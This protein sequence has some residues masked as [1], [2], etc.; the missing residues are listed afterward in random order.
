MGFKNFMQMSFTERK[1]LVS[2]AWKQYSEYLNSYLI[3]EETNINLWN[4]KHPASVWLTWR[5]L[6]FVVA[7]WETSVL[8]QRWEASLEGS[9]TELSYWVTQLTESIKVDGMMH[10][11]WF[12]H[13]TDQ[14]K[15]LQH[16]EHTLLT[17]NLWSRMLASTAW[18]IWYAIKAWN[19]IRF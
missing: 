16:I 2:L 8:L 3:L 13:Q 19:Q 18:Y 17:S 9:R 12:E 10:C 11:N 4:I 7:L 15:G 14:W 1:R 5:S 6:V